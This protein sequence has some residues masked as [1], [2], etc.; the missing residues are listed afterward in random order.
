LRQLAVDDMEI[1]P[2]YSASIDAKPNLTAAG[3]G[4]RTIDTYQRRTR[5][6]EDHR[7][8]PDR[9]CNIKIDFVGVPI[10]AIIR[11]G[12]RAGYDL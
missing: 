12:R 11:I 5:P 9:V 8:R 1:A 2:S 3:F 7:I 6:M 10:R 4:H